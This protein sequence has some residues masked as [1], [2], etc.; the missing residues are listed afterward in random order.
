MRNHSGLGARRWPHHSVTARLPRAVQVLPFTLS[1][2]RTHTQNVAADWAMM[3][4]C[5][6]KRNE[7]LMSVSDL[8]SPIDSAFLVVK[9]STSLDAEPYPCVPFEDH[10]ATLRP[11]PPIFTL[12]SIF[13]P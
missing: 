8:S 2:P 1:R 7:T 3:L 13:T 9:P 6:E 4:D 5:I 10:R 12:S 11:L